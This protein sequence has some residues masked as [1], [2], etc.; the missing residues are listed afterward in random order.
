M[1]D[2]DA[3]QGACPS[4]PHLP[5]HRFTSASTQPGHLAVSACCSFLSL[6]AAHTSY[7]PPHRT[8][9]HSV[10]TPPPPP[11]SLR[12]R[13]SPLILR[14]LHAFCLLSMCA[15]YTAHSHLLAAHLS[16]YH[17]AS[18]RSL[19]RPPLYVACSPATR[20]ASALHITISSRPHMA[21]P[22]SVNSLRCRRRLTSACRLCLLPHVAFASC[23]YLAHA[24]SVI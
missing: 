11:L 4:Q 22:P 13:P 1:P 24:V 2:A 21:L 14:R 5:D 8:R 18:E 9:R 23:P 12:A 6:L 20:L 17:L 3:R 7:T 16:C 15:V 10:H 19:H